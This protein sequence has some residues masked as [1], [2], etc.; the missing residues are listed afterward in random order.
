MKTSTFIKRLTSVLLVFALMIP[1]FASAQIQ[2]PND[3][4]K[5]S[6]GEQKEIRQ[7]KKMTPE[8]IKYQRV[9]KS[10]EIPSATNLTKQAPNKNAYRAPLAVTESGATLYGNLI[11]AAD[12]ADYSEVGYYSID[13]NTGEYT[14]VGLNEQLTGAGTVVEGIAYI[15]YAETYWGYILGLY[16]VVYDIE[17]NEIIEVIENDPS[18]FSAYALDMAYN[19]VEDVIYAVTY[20]YEGTKLVLSKFDRESRTYTAVCDLAFTDLYGMT[21]DTDG[22]LYIIGADGI[23]R[24]VD[25]ATGQYIDEVCNTGFAPAYLQSACWSPADGQILWAASNDTESYIIAIDV[26][27]GTTE[28][29]CSFGMIEEWVSLYTTDPMADQNAPAAPV[30]ACTANTPGLFT[31][32]IEAATPTQNLAGENLTGTYTFVIELNGEEIYNETVN[33]GQNI[34]LTEELA[35]G[36][37][38]VRAYG[39][40]DAGEGVAASQKVYAGNDTPMAVT[41][42]EVSVANGGVATL[43]WTA[44]AGGANDGYIDFSAITYNIERLG[45]VIATGVTNTTYVDQ[46]PSQM[47]Q[48]QWSVYAVFDGKVSEA[49]STDKVLYGEAINL[50]YEHAFNNAEC[51]DIY[52]I[53]DANQDGNTWGYSDAYQAI[54]NPY[55]GSDDADDYAFTPPLQLSNESTI[56]VEVNAKAYS[57]SYPEILEITLGTSTDPAAQTVIIPATEIAQTTPQTLRTYFTVDEPGTYHIGI[58]AISLAD[59]FY[60]LVQDIRVVNG[61]SF[62]APKAVQNVTATPGA[63]GALTATLSFTAP[64][65]TFG[66]DAL[67]GDVTVT[68]YRDGEVVGTTTCAPGATGS[69]VDNNAANGV[70][71]YILVTSNSA[72]NGEEYKISCRCGLDTP[73]IVTNVKFA[74]EEDNLTSIMSWEAP[75]TGAEGGYVDPA[76]LTYTIYVPTADGYNVEAIAETTDLS[77]EITVEDKTLQGYTYYVSAKND[78]GEG[79]LYGGSVVLGKPYELPFI[80]QIEG[81][82]L[83]N[84]PWYLY[85]PDQESSYA[86]WELGSSMEN[87]NLPEIVTAPDGGM[88][89]C[90][91]FWE[92]GAGSC[93]L[94]APKVALAGATAPTL[95]FSMYHYD[96]ADDINELSIE[97]TTDDTTYEEIFAKKVNDADANGWVEYQVSLSEYKDAPWIALMFNANIS[98]NGFIFIDYIK[99]ENASENDVMVQSVV[100]PSNVIIGEEAEFVAKVFNKGTNAASYDVTIYVND[101]ELTSMSESGLASNESKTYTATFTPTAENIG[102]LVVKAVVTMANDEVEGNNEAT[103][104]VMVSQ[105]HLRV[106]TDLAG[107]DD[108]K[109]TVSLTWS[110]PTI[111]PEPIVDDMEKYES[112]IIDNIGNYTIVDADNGQT[113]GINGV[114]MPDAFGPK[115]WQVWAP[116]EVGL[117]TEGWLPYSGEKCL[118]AFSTQTGSGPAD[119]WLITPELVGGTEIS[120]WANIPTIDYGPE[121]FE[122]LYSSTDNNITSFESIAQESKNTVGWEEYTYTLPADAKYFAIRYTSTDIFA[123]LIDDLSY[124]D[125]S[126]SSELAIVGYNVYLDGE[127]VNDSEV[128]GTN[129]DVNIT[130]NSASLNVTVVYNEGE[131]LFSN[132]V[133]I[134]E[135]GVEDLNNMGVN[136]YGQD[137]FIKIENV[138]GRVVSVYTVDGKVVYNAIAADNDIMIPANLGVYVVSIDNNASCKV[139][140]R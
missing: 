101:E 95:Y 25:T 65:E 81:T 119:D 41:D 51:L 29:L 97:I 110:A 77:Y 31:Y 138:A 123:L 107:T 114:D 128:L 14:A 72:G 113:Y 100:A 122:V 120:F 140:V 59:M 98:A 118:I 33:P 60:L 132:T 38:T 76:A 17:A 66:G 52:T 112:W 58:H 111:A 102:I 84:S 92:Y 64:T 43:T 21:F 45:E 3:F 136:V 103:T 15:S 46:L 125:P 69:I 7:G 34:T 74:T 62:D 124:A 116:A 13:P 94:Q 93:G 42:L 2:G 121:T 90:Y 27:A 18:D 47:A 104:N 106:V 127:K 39:I 26:T 28:T 89:I 24:T 19:H 57:T 1:T 4:L 11:Y 44:P 88:A 48:Y 78:I 53:V 5:R 12:W 10:S 8:M 49:A 30:L 70:N 16:T 96:T 9:V 37:N 68:A 40:N 137:D 80:E 22:N 54:Y 56:L 67:T 83:V 55:N 135:I 75:T 117:T 115:A 50:P 134:D 126:G 139:F 32:T 36:K 133:V 108:G 73:G 79:Q 23:V 20:D 86:T 109:G 82:T 6:K 35:E 105:P 99:V 87:Y 85:S 63:N 130:D 61:P 91:D 131:S 129:Y 71:E